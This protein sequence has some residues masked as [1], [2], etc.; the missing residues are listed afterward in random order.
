MMPTWTIAPVFLIGLASAGIAHAQQVSGQ[1]G[2]QSRGT[3]G[4]SISVAPR[5]DLARDSQAPGSGP[6]EANFLPSANS[7]ALRYTLVAE[8]AEARGGAAARLV[9]IV[10]D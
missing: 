3:I 6:A 4:I 1:M 9:L 5:F 10:P 8:K 2:A 7:S